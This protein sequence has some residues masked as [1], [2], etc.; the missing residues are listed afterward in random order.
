MLLNSHRGID[1]NWSTVLEN[2]RNGI[3]RG[4]KVQL[5]PD[6]E[7]LRL[8]HTKETVVT[9]Q[10]VFTVSFNNLRPYTSYRA[11][12]SAFTV[13]GEG[14]RG[15]PSGSMVTPEDVA[16]EPSNV[17]FSYVSE[18]ELR[19]KWMPPQ[20]PNG[21]I[22]NYSLRSWTD[23]DK[24][25][26]VTKFPHNTYGFSATTLMPHT[27]YFFGVQAETSVG[28]GPEVVVGVVTSSYRPPVVNPLAP[29]GH[30]TK[31]P[32]DKQIWI[33]WREPENGAMDEAPI[34]SVDIDFREDAVSSWTSL[35]YTILFSK[36]EALVP[37]LRPNTA[38]RFRIMFRGDF[39]QSDWSKESE[40]IQTSE[41]APS[42]PPE[43]LRVIPIESA[44]V[45]VQWE[46]PKKAAWNSGNVGYR[47]LYKI[48]PSN[49]S[50]QSEEVNE[51]AQPGEQMSHVIKKLTSFRHYIITVQTMNSLGNS[52]S[53][54]PKFVYVGYSV[55][56][57]RIEGLSGESLSSTSLR[58]TWD[59][60]NDQDGDAI[61]G[62]KVR[63]VQVVPLLEREKAMDDSTVIEEDVII[64]DNNS[65]ILVEL[66]KFS[67][68]QISVTGY[69]RA[70]ESESSIIRLTTLEDIPGPVS[71][72]SFS[73]ILLDSVNV[74]WSPPEQL[75]GNI[76][77]Y[78]VTYH[79]KDETIRKETVH[80]EYAVIGNLDEN[81]TYYF[82]V[83]AQTGAGE[84]EAVVGN[85]TIG[86]SPG[87]PESPDKP[88]LI[89]EQTSVIIRWH[90]GA[91]GS[92]PIKGHLVQAKRIASSKD[93]SNSRF[94]S[95]AK[96]AIDQRP[97][98]V[99]GEWVTISNIDG[100]R[101]DYQIDY[102]LLVPS[103]YY[104][105]R[106]FTRNTLGIGYPSIESEQL[107]VPDFIPDD[108]FYT[109]W[110]FI[111]MVGLITFVIIV[112]VISLLCVTGSAAKYRY[113][114]RRASVDSL[115][116]AENVVS[117]ELR[118]TQRKSLKHNRPRDVPS[119][120]DTNT[121]WISEFRDHSVYG[122][123]ADPGDRVDTGPY[124]ALATDVMPT[125][126]HYVMRG[127]TTPAFDVVSNL[128]ASGPARPA[129][130]VS[131]S[132]YAF[133][134]YN[135]ANRV[136]DDHFESINGQSLNCDDEP[137]ISIA[138]HYG[139]DDEIYRATWRRARDQASRQQ[140]S[141]SQALPPPPP[142]PDVALPHRPGSFTESGDS[143][144]GDDDIPVG[145]NPSVIHS[146][147][148]DRSV[149]AAPSR[150]S[151]GFS[152]FV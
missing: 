27:Q 145:D 136:N 143:E 58:V 152:S 150:V 12:V 14:P 11:F 29:E 49:E 48:Y 38:Y 142:P 15:S 106:L 40:L 101:S 42:S 93:S 103:S 36:K 41:A 107:H 123:I 117:Y 137:D 139:G 120:P 67:E 70:G 59:S 65:V 19:L 31:L 72:L 32:S 17:G 146:L 104:V 50:Y 54:R 126:S 69:N 82:S 133:A 77:S 28:L 102:R 7:R 122:S 79:K 99:I 88:V 56:K 84:G 110:W 111:V 94:S 46:V 81:A 25:S 21:K 100:A 131:E 37:N 71:S 57:Q 128:G 73:D 18:T 9:E 138:R 132:T 114:K 10:D 55:P 4:Y 13:V 52:V 129:S 75:N 130:E 87:A 115:Q 8:L 95:R 3:I 1:V 119:R 47:I 97:K 63:Y 35:P 124:G 149:T 53:A 6:E 91:P 90:D 23:N 96:R 113:D 83:K 33:R 105:F 121:S 24:K 80:G 98:H 89:P 45:R 134:K 109:K 16:G 86:A 76:V 39:S 78:S 43:D 64:S 118:G 112:I 2:E 144:F 20:Q 116:L 61:N 51:S 60:W 125:G 140:R 74:S 85:V 141:D 151:N 66:K 135:V 147:H 92:S 62:Y 5:V 108:P 22:I 26:V 34:R 148:D 127:G 30:Q 44:S 68:Y